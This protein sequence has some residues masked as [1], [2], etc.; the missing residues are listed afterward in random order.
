VVAGGSGSRFGAPKQFLELR[1]RRVID[2]AVETAAASSDG[3][4]VVLPV[5]VELGYHSVADTPVLVAV[6]GST[7][8]A[9]VTN[10][11]VL[12]PADAS[13]VLVHDAA[14]PLCP[15][16]VFERVVD[17]V[18]QGAKAV[19]PVLDV[20]DSLRE[21]AGTSVDRDG[22]VAVQ[23][24]QGFDADTLRRA[25]GEAAGD[26]ASDDATLVERIGVDVV[27]VAGHEASRKITQ[28]LDFKIAELI[29]DERS[30]H[31]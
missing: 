19:V 30:H 18:T 4:I 24:P 11:L 16:E 22:L 3:V 1:G 10:G 6:G 14:R 29:I 9:S 2:R 23:T 31:A 27:Q 28:P 21:R 5:N 15:A 26:A 25:Y 13:I 8:S 12:V 20:V 7:R 17:A